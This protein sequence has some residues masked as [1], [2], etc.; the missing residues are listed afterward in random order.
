M[1]EHILRA[2]FS[3]LI[4]KPEF[5]LMP[6]EDQERVWENIRT[7]AGPNILERTQT[8]LTR[9]KAESLWENVGHYPWSAN[10]YSLMDGANITA[11][12]FAGQQRA[13]D[14]KLEMRSRFSN[15]I[16][17]LTQQ[18]NAGFQADIF[19]GSDPGSEKREIKI[20]GI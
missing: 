12:I 20:L 5:M 17:A 14:T 10:Y 11:I 1:K 7:F 4:L 8:T 13:K 18:I 3:L 9:K 16:I 2:E 15:E 6:G 19:H